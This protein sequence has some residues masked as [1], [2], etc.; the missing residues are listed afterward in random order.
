MNMSSLLDGYTG[1]DGLYISY[2]DKF[3]PMY[4]IV[5]FILVVIAVGIY[6]KGK[7]KSKITE[8]KK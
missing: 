4:V 5:V 7:M 6:F 2:I 3:I 8:E 1:A